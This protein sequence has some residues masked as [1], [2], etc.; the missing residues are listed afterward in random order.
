M[1]TPLAEHV[2]EAI[3]CMCRLEAMLEKLDV[4]NTKTETHSIHKA[5]SPVV[6]DA[7][8]R[9]EQASKAVFNQHVYFALSPDM[10][11]PFNLLEIERSFSLFALNEPTRTMVLLKHV[12]DP[13]PVKEV[14]PA[15]DRMGDTV[16]LLCQYDLINTDKWIQRS[17]YIQSTV[18]R[19]RR[20]M[21]STVTSHLPLIG[22]TR[23]SC[24]KPGRRLLLPITW[25]V[26]V[27]FKQPR[28]LL[29]NWISMLSRSWLRVLSVKSQRRRIYAPGA[30]TFL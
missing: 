19:S 12:F 8:S 18:H 16:S 14:K 1:Q 11:N 25:F 29:E 27:S 20:A 24:I 21:F 22:R 15:A 13:D 28:P 30:G 23:G 5:F 10:F 26:S 9:L 7:I 3:V 4:P 2:S 6:K 17:L